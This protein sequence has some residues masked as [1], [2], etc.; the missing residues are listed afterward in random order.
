[1]LVAHRLLRSFFRDTPTIVRSVPAGDTNRAEF[2]A[3]HLAQ[4][5]AVLHHHHLAEDTEL[6]DRL[7]S[8]SPGCRVHVQLMRRQHA[9]MAVHVDAVDETRATWARAASVEHRER[10]A[11]ALEELLAALPAHLGDEEE[12][13]L[14]AASTALSQRAWN[15]LG[16]FANNA[17]KELRRH[18]L[19]ILGFLLDALGPVDGEA[20]SRRHLPPPV[21]LLYRAVGRPQYRAHRRRLYGTAA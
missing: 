4:L 6:W 9:A 17:P 5:T 10:L 1:M 19:V 12:L 16:E 3:D 7:S 13:I 18:Q 20:F 15:R 21:R 11:V 14:P 8:T 2:V